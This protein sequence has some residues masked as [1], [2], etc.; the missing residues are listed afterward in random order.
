MRSRSNML[1]MRAVPKRIEP[2]GRVVVSE[3]VYYKQATGPQKDSSARFSYMVRS[4]EQMYD[5]VHSLTGLESWAPVEPGWIAQPSTLVLTNVGKM[6]VHFGLR[7][8][9]NTVLT[10]CSLPAGQSTRI[11]NPTCMAR[12]VVS[13]D[14]PARFQVTTLPS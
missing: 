11:Q 6:P 12:L 8:D 7:V 10:L 9:S 13:S 2:T 14:G 1:T 3:T 4:D 5:R